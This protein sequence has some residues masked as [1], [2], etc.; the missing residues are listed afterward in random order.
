MDH[1][2]FMR[3]A[4]R[5][6]QQAKGRT[7]PNPLVGCV[8]VKDGKIIAEGYHRQAGQAHAEL[9]AIN[10][11][12]APITGATAYVN[13]EPCC[14]TNKRTPPCAQRL[15]A[16]GIKTVVIANTDPHPEV[17]GR[18]VA[19]LREAGIE[20]I[21]GILAHEGELLNEVFFYNQRAH[22]PFVHLKL[23]GTLDGR[24]AMADGQSQWITGEA[25]RLHAHQLR[26]MHMAIAVGAETLRRD[27]PQLTVRL[28]GYDGPQ[29]VRLVFSRS[30]NLPEAAKIFRDADGRRSQR[31]GDPDLD[32]VLAGL[33]EQGIV[34]LLVEGGAGLAG[35]FLAG[36][37]VQR[38][39]HYLNPSYLGQGKS[40]V[41]DYGLKE[42]SQRIHLKHVEYTPLGEDFLITGRV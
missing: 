18:G 38:I 24:I 37:H 35:S 32:A 8:L 12:S 15:I 41:T 25:A 28:P 22:K 33:Y 13:L 9:D 10:Q 4:L 31:I 16:E 19:M 23:A 34:N 39:S 30:G 26:A 1:A 20:V 5:L 2:V 7:W 40:A 27:D 17:N 29:P 42:L 3:Q 21:T 14:H 36:G 11:A 6:A